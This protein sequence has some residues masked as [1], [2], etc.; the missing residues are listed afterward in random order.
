MSWLLMMLAC[1]GGKDS[2]VEATETTESTTSGTDDTA[3]ATGSAALFGNLTCTVPG[4]MGKFYIAVFDVEPFQVGSATVV[5][6]A[7]SPESVD[8]SSPD[9]MAAYRVE[10]IPTRADPYYVVAFVDINNN[11]EATQTPDSG[12][13]ISLDGSGAYSTTLATDGE[14][15]QLDMVFNMAMP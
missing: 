7:S 13:I 5:A 3:T 6:Q 15:V 2:G 11:Y 4:T 12:D 9:K 1:S 14:E 8:L 10:D